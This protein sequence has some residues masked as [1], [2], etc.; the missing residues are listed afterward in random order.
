M[1][2]FQREVID[3]LARI[4]TKVESHA[5]VASRVTNLEK[6]EGRRNAIV[7]ALAA[8]PA[9]AAALWAAVAKGAL[10]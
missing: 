9:G 7:A 5:D 6:A 2:P 4:E 10:P 3:R 1:D 8:V